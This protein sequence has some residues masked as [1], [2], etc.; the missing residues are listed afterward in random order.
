MSQSYPEGR[1]CRRPTLRGDP[2]PLVRPSSDPVLVQT[3]CQGLV[4]PKIDLIRAGAVLARGL[5]RDR[6]SPSPIAQVPLLAH[7]RPRLESCWLAVALHAD[8]AF[9]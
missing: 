4:G 5:C 1:P 8:P 9:V 2:N 6:S 7:L 3:I